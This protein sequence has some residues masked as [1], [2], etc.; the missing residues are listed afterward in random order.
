MGGEI[1][2]VDKEVGERGTCFRFN[3]FLS[4]FDTDSSSLNAGAADIESSGGYI[5]CDS[6]RHS[7]H[8]IRTHSPKTEGSQVVLL[9][10]SAKRSNLVQGF[11]QRL[12]IKVHVID[13]HEHLSPALKRIKQKLNLSHYSSSGK[14]EGSARSKQVPLSAL[15]GTDDVLPS[16]RKTNPN[17]NARP[18]LSG[19]VMVVID[20]RAGPFR[21]ISRAVA[22]F[23][24][25]LNEN[26]LSRLVWLDKADASSTSSFRG[27][28][29][30]KLP[31]SDLVISKPFHGSRLYQTIQLLPEFGGVPPRRAEG[32]I[33]QNLENV[34]YGNVSTF[35]A[36]KFDVGGRSGVGGNISGNEKGEIEEVGGA[37]SKKPLMGK[38]IVVVDDDPIGRKI[39]TFVVS[40]LGAVV[41]SCENGEEAWRLVCKSLEDNAGASVPFDCVLMDCEVKLI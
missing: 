27:L 11:M 33:S 21:E 12:G 34:Q 9:I 8:V 40:Q 10:K 20:T 41:I 24:R 28:D 13:K 2:I 18:G 30:D 39:A 14:S 35:E 22:E 29:E 5:S 23:R 3:V 37:N 7:G 17:A 36:S 4:T 32:E 1:G 25:D 38:K 31:P 6:F 26:C 19:F 15:D 16:Q